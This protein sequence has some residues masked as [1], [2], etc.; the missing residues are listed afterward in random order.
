MQPKVKP[1]IKRLAQ[2]Q[3]A[4]AAEANKKEPKHNAEATAKPKQHLEAEATPETQTKYTKDIDYCT[5]IS[6]VLCRT[7][8]RWSN[9]MQPKVKPLIKR[10]AQGQ[11]AEA[12]EAT[13][14][15]PKHNAEATTKPTQQPEA[16][17]TRKAR[18][19]NESMPSSPSWMRAR[20]WKRRRSAWRW[21]QY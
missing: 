3:E 12:T 7:F 21:L 8:S 6:T 9:A 4:E 14:K 15:E 1:L 11:E 16:E 2:G 19:L 17:A 5:Q 10:L 18:K 20:F 13:K